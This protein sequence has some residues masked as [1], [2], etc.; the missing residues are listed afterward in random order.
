MNNTKNTRKV[1][2]SIMILIL[3]ISDA[4]TAASGVRDGIHMCLNVVIPSLFPFFIITTYIN[5]IM[6]GYRVPGLQYITHRLR[7]PGGGE[8]ILLLG[9]TGGYPVGAKLIAD[10]YKENII[11][12]QTANIL[13]GYCNNAGPA[14]IF[15]IAGAAFASPIIPL[16]LW[17]IHIISAVFTGFLL[18][19]PELTNIK[20]PPAPKVSMTQVISGSI[21]ACI[22]VCGWVIVFKILLTY[23]NTWFSNLFLRPIGIILTG[24]L[25]LSNGCIAAEQLVNPSTRFLLFAVFFAFGGICVF[26]QTTSV[27]E[28][29]G[30][31]LYIHGKIIQTCISLIAACICSSM[32]FPDHRLPVPLMFITMIL[33]IT[34]VFFTVKYSKKCWKSGK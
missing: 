18:P 29:L 7:I 10:L 26:L 13:L 9:L 3:I 20:L 4:K 11:S 30:S 21:S 15:G 34:I 6:F 28:P 2:M 14:F 25:E 17:I 22:S 24:M 33:A 1:I 5:S 32:L 16:I 19:K 8:S 31:G 12:R 27:T 23:L